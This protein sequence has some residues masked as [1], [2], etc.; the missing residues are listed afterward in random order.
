MTACPI[1]VRAVT[2]GKSIDSTFPDEAVAHSCARSRTTTV[3]D[4]GERSSRL[5]GEPRTAATLKAQGLFVSSKATGHCDGKV[6]ELTL[7]RH[8]V[9]GVA[10]VRSAVARTRLGSG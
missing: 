6:F 2:E 4:Q 9:V 8:A 1:A 10:R 3:P 7:G 5:I